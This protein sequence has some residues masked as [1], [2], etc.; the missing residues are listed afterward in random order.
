MSVATVKQKLAAGGTVFGT[1]LQRMTN[2]AFVAALPAE[3]L[4]FVVCNTEHN[5]LNLSD[6]LP[7]RCTL[8]AHGIACVA[9]VH[10]RVPDDIAKVCDTYDGVVIPYVEDVEEAKRLVAAAK[11]RP[12]KGEALERV[13]TTGQWPSEASREYVE[14]H[15][16]GTLC[17]PMIESVK[18]IENLDAICQIP[19]VDAVFVG[20]NDL[21]VSMGIPEQRDHP[22][23]IEAMQRIIDIAAKHGIA[24]GAHFS[25]LAHAQRLIQQGGRFIPFSADEMLLRDALAD[26]LKALT[27][28]RPDTIETVI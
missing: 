3:G 22:D 13:I 26:S 15:N 20:P 28:T 17:L 23:F 27:G 19:G 9:R 4:D 1:F 18:S 21:S 5:A 8:K 25:K 11:Y 10:S 16:A 7:M 6:F 2:P 14:Q 24:A 12:L